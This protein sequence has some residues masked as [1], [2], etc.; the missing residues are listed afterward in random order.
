MIKKLLSG[1]HAAAF[2]QKG[3]FT[4][5][6]SASNSPRIPGPGLYVLPF[7]NGRESFIVVISHTDELSSIDVVSNFKLFGDQVSAVMGFV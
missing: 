4:F 6:K 3:P 5:T 2:N 7:Q 1:A